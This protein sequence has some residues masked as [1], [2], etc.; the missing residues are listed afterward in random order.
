MSDPHFSMTSQFPHTL[1]A[2][3]RPESKRID[4]KKSIWTCSLSPDLCCSY[5]SLIV[6]AAG[7][8]AFCFAYEVRLKP[9]GQQLMDKDHTKNYNNYTSSAH[10]AA[11]SPSRY[12]LENKYT[13]SLL[14]EFVCGEKMAGVPVVPQFHPVEEGCGGHDD[15]YIL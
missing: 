12:S 10:M 3:I 8:C 9:S 11:L 5:Y 2:M 7:V 4:V 1:R 6:S 13:D 15:V 14:Y